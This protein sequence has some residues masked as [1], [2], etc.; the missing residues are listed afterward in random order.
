MMYELLNAPETPG[1]VP[2][3]A[4]ESTGTEPAF[5]MEGPALISIF[6]DTVLEAML[7]EVASKCNAVIACRVS[8][9]QKAVLV[10][11]VKQYVKPTPVTLSIGD[12]ANDVP[13]LQEAQV[14][15]GI[16]GKEGQQAVNNSDFAVAQFRQR[17]M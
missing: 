14:G 1:Y 5:I 13:M 4:P 16:S 11:M 7:F 10:R 9:K 6:G 2:P 3:Q 12:G 8:P 17:I 15:V